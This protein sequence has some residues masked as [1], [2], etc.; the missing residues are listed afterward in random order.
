MDKILG[1]QPNFFE[2]LKFNA[3]LDTIALIKY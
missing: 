2:Y 1:N 3:R